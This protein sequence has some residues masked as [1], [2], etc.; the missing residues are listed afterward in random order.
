MSECYKSVIWWDG[1]YE[2]NCIL[3]L[4]RIPEDVHTDGIVWFNDDNEEID[5]P[6]EE[7]GH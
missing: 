7:D 5:P 6:G 2:G 3:P 1:E 4:D